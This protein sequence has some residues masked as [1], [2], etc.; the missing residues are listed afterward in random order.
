MK[1][2]ISLFCIKSYL[3]LTRSLPKDHNYQKFITLLQI[4]LVVPQNL[5]GYCY[6]RHLNHNKKIKQNTICRTCLIWFFHL[7]AVPHGKGCSG[8]RELLLVL[9]G[10]LYLVPFPVLKPPATGDTSPDYLSE[11]FSLLVVPSLTSLRANQKSRSSGGGKTTEQQG[12]LI[13][14][15]H[16]TKHSTVFHLI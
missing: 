13:L 9:E 10:D 12:T 6:K 8:R 14:L 11:R 7:L 16:S 15:L 1:T 3:T 5:T 4:K 2:I